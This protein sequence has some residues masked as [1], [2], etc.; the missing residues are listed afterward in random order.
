MVV[1]WQNWTKE[2][3]TDQNAGKFT[4]EG[5][6]FKLTDSKGSGYYMEPDQGQYGQKGRGD[7]A[8]V[9]VSKFQDDPID[10]EGIYRYGDHRRLL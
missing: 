3:W 4:K 10:G 5:Y 9:Y 1:P 8:F 7:A 2:Q 6:W